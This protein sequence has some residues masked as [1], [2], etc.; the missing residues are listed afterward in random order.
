MRCSV[1]TIGVAIALACAVSQDGRVEDRPA[2]TR[3]AVV[4]AIEGERLSERMLDL[5][6]LAGTRLPQALDAEA[7]WGTRADD[8]AEVARAIAASAARIPEAAPPLAAA[9]REEFTA[10]AEALRSRA[11]ALA[12]AAER[13]EEEPLRRRLAELEAA[14]AQCH[15]RFRLPR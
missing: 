12:E 3:P 2:A 6:R 9:E 5:D 14:C 10:L 13:R 4:H 8:V 15:E 1:A 7:A 11:L